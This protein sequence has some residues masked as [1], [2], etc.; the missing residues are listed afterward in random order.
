MDQMRRVEIGRKG[1]IT[2]DDRYRYVLVQ[3]DTEKGGGY[4]ILLWVDESVRN[5]FD[6]WVMNKAELDEYFEDKSW[7]ID[8]L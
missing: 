2:G 4:F 3:Q 8:W 7:T 1:R 5:T 6:D